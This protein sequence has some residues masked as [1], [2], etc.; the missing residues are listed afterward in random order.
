MCADASKFHNKLR[1][2]QVAFF[3]IPEFDLLI[4]RYFYARRM[5]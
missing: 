1:V 3:R 5:E 4:R 2:L